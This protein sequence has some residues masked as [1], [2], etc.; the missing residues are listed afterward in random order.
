MKF[1]LYLFVLFVVTDLFISTKK[2]Q[3]QAYQPSNRI[4]IADSTLGTQVT[5]NS[6]NFTINGGVSRGQNTFHSFQDFSVP[7]NGSATFANP[8]G[9]Q[10]IITRVT[11]NLFS[12]INGTINTQ[13]ANFLLINP[14]GVVF[15][16]STQLNVGRVFAAST[17]NGVDL[18]DGGGRT[19]SFGTNAAGDGALLSIDPKVI[20][21]VSRLNL[22]GGNGEIK[23]FGTLQTNNP[24]QYIGLV[25][26]NVNLDAG[27]INAPGGRIE[28]GGLSAP[29]S[30]EIS[31]EGGSPRLNFPIGVDRSNLILN[32]QARVSVA[33][34]GSGDIV[35]NTHNADLLGDS[36]IRGGIEENLGAKN[37]I[38]GD[39]N[40]KATGAIVVDNSAIVNNVR[41]NSQGRAG[42]INIEANKL[43]LGKQ[44][45][46]ISYVL[47]QGDAGSIQLKVAEAIDISDRFSEIRSLVTRDGVGNAGNI[48]INTGSLALRNRAIIGSVLVGQGNSGNVSINAKGAV[49]LE[50]ATVT[51]NGATGNTGNATFN[52]DSLSLINGASINT[53]SFGRGN[54]GNI[55]LGV[56]SLSIT[57]GSQLSS[58][59]FGQGNAGNIFIGTGSLALRNNVAVVS[60]VSGQGNGGNVSVSAKGAIDLDSVNLTTSG[61][62]GNS[63][64]IT[65]NA[66]SLSLLNG[67]TIQASSFG[68]GNAGNINFNTGSLSII[69]SQLLSLNTGQG[70]A[71][72][73]SLNTGSLAL[74][75]DVFI[76]T[77]VTGQGNSG[78]ILVNA[79]GDVNLDGA[80]ITT[81]MQGTA[82]NAG[83]ITLNADSLSLLN[84][85]V[86]DASSFG[87]GNAGNINIKAAQAVAISG[88]GQGDTPVRAILG[89]NATGKG[90]SITI[91]ANSF[92][93][94]NAQ[95]RTASSGQGNAGNIRISAKNDANFSGG[96]SLASSITKT[97]D[98]KAGDIDV[99]S[100]FLSIT[101]GSQILA[102]SNGKGDSGSIS[103]N[104]SG[105]V[106]LS[107]TGSQIQNNI[108][109]E[110]IGNAGNI[111]VK[112]GSIS[113]QDNAIVT[114]FTSG[115]GNAGNINVEAGSISLQSDATVSTFSRG[116]GNA[117]NITVVAK[118]S[119]DISN[120]SAAL[121][122]SVLT[123]AIGKGGN[124][125]VQA[126]SLSLTGGA[127]LQSGNIGM[128]S[129]GNIKVKVSGKLDI[130]GTTEITGGGISTFIGADTLGN[131][132][133]I[134]IE[135]SSLSLRNGAK[136]EASNFGQGNAGTIS[137]KAT[138]SILLT[139]VKERG[140]RGVFVTIIG[141]DA[142]AGNIVILAPQITLDNGFEINAESL[143]GRGGNISIGSSPPV[144]QNNVTTPTTD[145][146]LLRNGSK[147]LT[148]AGGR[149]QQNSDGGNIYLKS[150]LIVAV[151][152]ENSDV[153]ANAIT[154]RGGNV[155]ITAQG[156]IGTQ[157]RARQTSR[158]DIT[159][160][161]DFGQNGIVN[162]NT[163][164]IDPGKDTNELPS[165]PTDASKQITQTC[166]SSQVGNKFH[167]TGRGG[168]PATSEDSLTQEVV[169]LDPRNQKTQVA[170][171]S[172][173]QF[174]KK[175]SQP[176]VGWKFD[177]NGKVTLLAA[178]NEKT[179]YG[180]PVACPN[181]TH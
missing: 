157:F 56:N 53:I 121:F 74:K 59:N 91:D 63:G 149:N 2:S 117:G 11:G 131:A 99:N 54:A 154:G 137:I 140:F 124:I 41:T 30:V 81:N 69:G 45:G 50:D 116:N 73:I 144:N 139:G 34:S 174:V 111:N 166:N 118:D 122:S 89:N 114:S 145:L 55:N 129:S 106:F 143:S 105:S 75:K 68:K 126:G 25:G 46:I 113:L 18:I 32:N 43:S 102:S 3:A 49:D 23:N 93:L 14:N 36:T 169:W 109:N 28:L 84:G 5:G 35:I 123:G 71:G 58:A 175:I 136:F 98:G 42:N 133:D 115:N 39:I 127:L 22:G 97:G 101:E 176:T 51:T 158:S 155:N 148:N 66:D 90:G 88:S 85:S 170:N 163:P 153:T 9:N 17:A 82:G 16:P 24:G 138:D 6:S 31:T 156:V 104:T 95:I 92:S 178:S 37:A 83:N 132:G 61:S 112:A 1:S 128:G 77:S 177:G 80:N 13:G 161:S 108:T 125:N 146:L 173:T 10:G 181:Q 110:A 52:A 70:N 162:I 15:G 79:K 167:I 78:N 44:G 180:A 72:D 48:F 179:S 135:A 147:I 40:L 171:N 103:I 119:I 94:R 142:V 76:S 65:F 4:P 120:T 152:Q 33:D 12:D 62:A 164:G 141:R 7:T 57:N 64:N 21:N 165:T 168:H 60:S 20:F 96:G 87:S 159:A 172:S 29:G 130:V 47:G 86:I 150:G 151:P 160:S 134:I 8:L 100:N 67:T 38:A 107:G 19:L 26:G 27:K